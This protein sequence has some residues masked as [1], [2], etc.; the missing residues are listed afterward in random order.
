MYKVYRTNSQKKKLINTYTEENDN[1]VQSLII[2]LSTLRVQYTLLLSNQAKTAAPPT[3]PEM[4]AAVAAVAAVAAAFASLSLLFPP[5]T[6][7]KYH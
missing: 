7:L 2:S 5:P 3:L 4:P 6:P 1:V